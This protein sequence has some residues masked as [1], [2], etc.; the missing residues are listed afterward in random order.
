MKYEGEWEKPGM[1]Y[2]E[3]EIT[4][5]FLSSLR[6]PVYMMPLKWGR[7]YTLMRPKCRDF[8][9]LAIYAECIYESEKVE[10]QSLLVTIPDCRIVTM[11]G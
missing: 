2:K 8:S 4:S 10:N 1:K 3:D 11:L 5:F 6:P 7:F 9:S